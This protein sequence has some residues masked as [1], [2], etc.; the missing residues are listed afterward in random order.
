MATIEKINGGKFRIRKQYKGKLYTMT[1]DRKPTKSEAEQ[2]IWSIID[3]GPENGIHKDFEHVAEDY[4]KSKDAVLSPTTISGYKSIMRNMPESFKIKP[5]SAVSQQDIQ[6]CINEY[7]KHHSSKSVRNLSGFITSVMHSINPTFTN[8]STLP[9]KEE[10][11]FYVP[12]DSDIKKILDHADGTRYE[13]ALWLATYGMR[14][15]EICAL[16]VSDL[17]EDNIITVNKAKVQDSEGHWHIKTVKTVQS[18]RKFKIDDDLAELIRKKDEYVYEGSP[19]QINEY[20]QATQKKLGIEK[21]SLHKMR[22]YFASTARE[23]MP[24][25]YVEKLGGW[26]PGSS[27]MKKVYDYQKKKQTDEASEAFINRLKKLS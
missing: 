11:D 4:I 16:T 26:K 17:S 22:H 15:S 18:A 1:L 7:A 10:R 24:D 23:V 25:S 21:F 20:L 14:R 6:I 8:T 13:I 27:I 5:I 3:K 2:L 9:Q 19:G 12:E